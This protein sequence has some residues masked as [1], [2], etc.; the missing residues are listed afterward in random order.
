MKKLYL[1]PIFFL[2]ACIATAQPT[3]SPQ[4]A[5][6]RLLL[7]NQRYVQ[8]SSTCPDRSKEK[9]S[10]IAL[11]QTP[12]AVVLGCSDS[13]VSP[14]IIFDQ[15]IGD[16]FVV[17]V[18]GNVA[19]GVEMASIEYGVIYLGASVILVLGHENCAAVKAV[20]SGTT[21]DIEEIAVLLAPALAA[22]KKQPSPSIETAVKDNVRY[23]VEQLSRNGALA[24]L[25]SKKKLAVVGGYYDFLSGKIEIFTPTK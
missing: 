2:W 4:Q 8:G 24:D 25:I 20:M 18:A 9:R 15:G 13:R 10:D 16:L 22:T 12:F 7:G 19:G 11:T 1:F 6:E 21:K 14:E 23:V 3:T 17:R 5:L